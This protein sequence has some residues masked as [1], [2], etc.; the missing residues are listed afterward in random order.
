MFQFYRQ[1]KE[2]VYLVQHNVLCRSN[3]I[4]TQTDKSYYVLSGNAT[5]LLDD[6]VISLSKDDFVFVPKETTLA[7]KSSD[8]FTALVFDIPSGVIEQS[9]SLLGATPAKERKLPTPN[10]TTSP[11]TTDSKF[12]LQVKSLLGVV[13][14]NVTAASSFQ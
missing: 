7:L 4:Y 2:L 11:N 5:L 14:V 12:A 10:E 13:S 1:L 6:K 8:N 9:L 3:A